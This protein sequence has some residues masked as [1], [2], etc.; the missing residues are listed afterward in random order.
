MQRYNS[1]RRFLHLLGITPLL[2]AC[3]ATQTP[4]T[5]PAETTIPPDATSI[6]T[7]V[8]NAPT[9]IPNPAPTAPVQPQPPGKQIVR[10]PELEFGVVGH[11][12]YT[13][14]SRVLTLTRIAGFDWIRQQIHWKDIESSPGVYYWDEV[15]HIVEDVSANSVKLLVNIVQA[16]DFYNASNGKPADPSSMGNFVEALAKRYGAQISA[17]E[18]WNEPNLAVENGGRVSDEDPGRYAE[19]LVECYKRIK[20]VEPSIIVLLAAPSST[21]VRN[22][23]I[24]MPDEEYLRAVYRYKD[25]IVNG[26]FDAQAVHPGA[27]ANPPNTLFPQNPSRIEGCLPAPDKCWN[28]DRTHYFRHIENIRQ[29]MVEE[30]YGEHQLWITEYGWAT[31]N[32]TPGFEFGQFTSLE[33]QADYIT[34]AITN[35]Y[36][37]Y[38][39]EQGRPWV[40][41][42]FL[43]NMNF[44][45]LWA[46]QGN[47]SHEQ[48]SFSI[49]N[50]DWSPRPTFIVLQGLHQEIK[51]LQGR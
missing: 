13:D 14:R 21:G 45:V 28:D 36:E 29:I 43:W 15:D 48:A 18:I 38:R 42:M 22:E 49:L 5:P 30:G 26:H 47:T 31:P 37:S 2:A 39:D 51:Q 6:A 27:A 9:S 50:P 17:I 41:A 16:P 7:S 20:A 44:A 11:L 40:G 10:L 12:Y 33:R 19:L 32:N 8:P 34:Q 4:I 23:T 3:G 25:G 1:R 24:A 35:V 46:A